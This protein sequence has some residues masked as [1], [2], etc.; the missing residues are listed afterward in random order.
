[1]R[2]RLLLEATAEDKAA[3]KKDVNRKFAQIDRVELLAL[4]DGRRSV[5]DL[6]N[7]LLVRLQDAGPVTVVNIEAVFNPILNDLLYDWAQDLEFKHSHLFQVQALGLGFDLVDQVLKLLGLVGP[8]RPTLRELQSPGDRLVSGQARGWIYKAVVN[9][10][11]DIKE[12]ARLAI[13][14]GKSLDKVLRGRDLWERVNARAAQAVRTWQAEA[15]ARA[16]DRRLEQLAG[17]IPNLKKQFLTGG[18]NPCAQCRSFATRTFSVV[19]PER[20]PRLPLHPNCNCSYHPF[21]LGVTPS[22]TLKPRS[23]EVEFEDQPAS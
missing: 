20:G 16:T 1:M 22:V 3:Y 5:D 17:T 8:A 7:R 6:K 21:I 4:R 15:L 23:G 11:K 14:A 13:V 18:A 19:G 12:E 9:S 2:S 10:F